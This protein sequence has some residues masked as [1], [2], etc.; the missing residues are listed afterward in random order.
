MS[1]EDIKDKT[2]PSNNQG[3]QNFPNSANQF[4]CS[5]K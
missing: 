5:F 4:K 1:K 3:S 2:H